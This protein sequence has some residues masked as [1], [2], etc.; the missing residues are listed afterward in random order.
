MRLRHSRW[1]LVLAA[2]LLLGYG[3]TAALI[4]ESDTQ[5][6]PKTAR[7][8]VRPV[9]VTKKRP[10]LGTPTRLEIPKLK[11]SAPILPVGVTAANDMDVP[12]SASETGWY[13]F[14]AIPGHPGNAV[15][16][17][18]LGLKDD[19]AVFWHLDKLAAGDTLSVYDAKHRHVR[20]KVTGKEYYTP[21]TAPRERIFGA[22]KDVNLNLI[23]CNG[24]Y[25][26]TRDDYTKRLVVY[27]QALI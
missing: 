13:K 20:F 25:I 1:L 18:H 27:T 4:S 12:N 9:R 10:V 23:T 11:I 22:T 5:V 6:Q 24:T 26:Q 17:G 2:G 7:A 16:A 15:L 19:P 14:G 3:V 21:E 8:Q